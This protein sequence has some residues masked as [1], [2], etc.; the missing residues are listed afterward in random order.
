MEYWFWYLLEGLLAGWLAGTFWRGAGY[1]PLGDILLGV[2]GSVL[3]GALFRAVGLAAYGFL[4]SVIMAFVGAVA[5]LVV[6][7]AVK[8]A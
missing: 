5:F 4:G 8:K 3:G 6:A 2:V 1:G 7:R